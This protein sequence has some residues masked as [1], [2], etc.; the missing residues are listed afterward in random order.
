MPPLKGVKVSLPP[1]PGTVEEDELDEGAK[2]EVERSVQEAN[3]D[4]MQN[5]QVRESMALVS[6]CP[7]PARAGHQ[8]RR[9]AGGDGRV[10]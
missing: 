5:I 6:C 2:E 4:G 10:R 9:D 8:D 7:G 1:Q 3:M